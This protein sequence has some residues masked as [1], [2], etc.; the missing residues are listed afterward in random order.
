M[1]GLGTIVNCGMVALGTTLGL[2]LKGGLP[3][4]FEK[5]IMSALSLCAFFIG[6]G[7]ALSQ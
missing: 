6:L 3:Q 5:T 1:T 4:R 7:G 2:L